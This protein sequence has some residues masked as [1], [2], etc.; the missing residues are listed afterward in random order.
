[1]MKHLLNLCLGLLLAVC[2]AAQGEVYYCDDDLL[3][4]LWPI[5]ELH[6]QGAEQVYKEL[7][8]RFGSSITIRTQE[9][10]DKI[11][12]AI[13][14]AVIQFTGAATGVKGIDLLDGIRNL[15]IPTKASFSMTLPELFMNE[16][17]GETHSPEFREALAALDELMGH[18]EAY[19][20]PEA[21]QKLAREHLARLPIYREKLEWVAGVST[22]YHSVRYWRY[23]K[24]KWRDLIH[25]GSGLT[26]RADAGDGDEPPGKKIAKADVT[27]AI[28]GVVWGAAAG[29]VGGTVVVPGAGTLGGAAAGAVVG[30][31]GN[32]LKGS[33]N[34]AIDSFVDWLFGEKPKNS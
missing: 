1:M 12:Q 11:R 26:A 25:N 24:P 28:K 3:A 15:T 32:G 23:E 6:N 31:V 4:R 30:G 9:D 10:R 18:A 21:F 5:G 34:A 2:A 14:D 27:G 19:E 20:S 13:D 22:A 17:E 7:V 16:A 29:A 33:V 8:G